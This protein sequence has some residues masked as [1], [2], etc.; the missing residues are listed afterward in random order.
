MKYVR[1]TDDANIVCRISSDKNKSFL[2]KN[3]K[4]DKINGTIL[5]NG[6]TEISDEEIEILRAE[7]DTFKYYETKGRLTVV[8]NLPFESMSAEQLIAVLRTENSILKQELRELKAG[9]G[10]ND[11]EQLKKKIEELE[12]LNTKQELDLAAVNEKLTEKE[13]IIEALDLQL[14]EAAEKQKKSKK[15]EKED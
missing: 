7:S 13:K 5:S 6:Y 2:F 15:A 10:K 11:N 3:K 8:E 4:I 14:T 9:A 1:N 12:T